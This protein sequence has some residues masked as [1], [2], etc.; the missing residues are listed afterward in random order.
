MQDPRHL[1]ALARLEWY[2]TRFPAT[3]WV[4]DYFVHK[5]RVRWQA[6][7]WR[8]SRHPAALA[9]AETRGFSQ[10]GEDGIIAEIFRRIG[11]GDRYAVEFG[12]ADGAECCTRQLITADGWNALLIEGMPGHAAKAQALYAG[13]PH[14]RVV[15]QMLN[16]DN[17]LDLFRANRVPAAPD[18]LV[19][20]VDGND[21][22]LWQR[23]LSAYRPRVAVVE[24]NA[25]WPAHREW[26]MDY[27]A[28]KR[29]AWD[30]DIGAS[31]ASLAKLGAAHG[32]ALV[33]CDSMGV[34]AF[35]VRRD[36]LGSHFP[37]HAAGL[38]YHYAPPRYG[39]GYGHPLRGRPPTAAQVAAYLNRQREREERLTPPAPPEPVSKS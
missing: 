30:M 25:W 37:D 5:P 15:C 34:N 26:V 21:Y 31:L 29:W 2:V 28:E 39:R 38:A 19:V 24:Y 32:Y 16:L 18:L 8:R 1:P 10:N 36:Q 14:A 23:I 35:F 20:D 12:V 22:W 6:Y 3:A 17:I 4:I 33:G 11:P 7:R 13:H 9:F 27:D